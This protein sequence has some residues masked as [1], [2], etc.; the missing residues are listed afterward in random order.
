MRRA[1]GEVRTSDV[2]IQHAGYEDASVF[3]RKAERN[4]RLLLLQQQDTPEDPYNLLYLGD[5]LLALDRPA[6]ALPYLQ[7][8]LTLL[9]L[10]AKARQPA[11]AK[12]A[13]AYQLVGGV[14]GV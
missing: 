8:S 14:P 5:C 3:R 7:R 4:L 1:G 9:P 6:E 12:L 13:Q 2:V 10:T 11:A